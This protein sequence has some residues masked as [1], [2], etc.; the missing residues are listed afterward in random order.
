MATRTL[1]IGGA[2][3][4]VVTAELEYTSV[5]ET[6]PD[7]TEDL[8]NC[9]LT[10]VV[11]YSDCVAT[12]WVLNKGNRRP[13]YTWTTLPRTWAQFVPKKNSKVGDFTYGVAIETGG[14]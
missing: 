8:T 2:D 13:A 3:G 14:G 5:G 6:W 9:P 1:S 10:R 7:G 4:A 12:L 11:I